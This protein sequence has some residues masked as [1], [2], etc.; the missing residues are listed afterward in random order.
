MITIWFEPHSTTTDNE[1]NL[2]SG[3]NDIDLSKMGVEQTLQPVERSRERGIEI[4]FVSD[5]QRAIK[6]GAPT[7]KELRVPM[8]VD[9]RLRECDYGD[10]TQAPKTEVEAQKVERIS[11][12]F[13]NGESYE[14]V[15]ARMKSFIDYLKEN[16]DGKTVMIVG[17]RGTHYGL[18]HWILQKPLE[19]CVAE[20][21]VYQP[22]W[23]YE[24]K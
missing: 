9:E 23:K 15:A 4:I 20:K 6:T 2:A 19:E 5:L 22:G 13:P 11:D 17:H 10:L 7:A 18:D 8:Y 21:F 14:Q 24:L 1:A 3:W 12:P 16:F